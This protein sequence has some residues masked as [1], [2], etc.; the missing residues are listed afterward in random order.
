MWF[1]CHL[2]PNTY[3]RIFLSAPAHYIHGNA[4][5]LVKYMYTIFGNW[6]K[7]N[8]SKPEAALS[9]ENLIQGK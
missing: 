3:Q 5:V 7:L 1:I 6:Y 8:I 4:Q 2:F 9:F